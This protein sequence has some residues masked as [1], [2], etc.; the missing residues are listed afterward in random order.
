MNTATTTADDPSTRGAG[1]IRRC[2]L[3]Q[4]FSA[5]EGL[6]WRSRRLDARRLVLG[7]EPG[8]GELVV[9]DGKASRRHCELVHQPESGRYRLR[10]LGSKNG[11][12]LDAVRVESEILLGCAVVRVGGALFVYNEVETPLRFDQLPNE[13]GVSPV[14]AMANRMID[15]AASAELPVL[16]TGPTG[17]GKELLARRLHE[18]SGRRG[19]FVPV[20]CAGFSR[21]LVGSELFGHVK[22]AFSGANSNRA[23]LFAAAAEGTIFLDEIADLPLDQQPALLRALQDRRIRPVGADREQSV[24]A[25]V[26]TATH[27]DLDEMQVR[28][29]FRDD[30]YA[31]IASVHVRLP[32]L[33]ERREELLSL[34]RDAAGYSMPPLQ[35]EAAEALLLH[36]WPYNVREVH[37]AAAAVRL[38]AGGAESLGPDLLPAAI[39]HSRDARLTAPEADTP[40][41]P[42]HLS[43]LMKRHAGN[44]T[45]VGRALGRSRQQIY[46]LLRLY[47]LDLD[48][49]R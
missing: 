46:R 42:T 11:T 30:L 48:D 32:G 40:I 16:I 28:G 3:T 34:F 13:V 24:D 33:T 31:R 27:R 4:V 5:T 6:L 45:D 41:D 36:G 43:R 14:R 17:A 26:V 21:E 47:R 15:L 37:Q 7:R 1:P 38:F 10:D 23:G 35:L 19:P 8:D 18:A 49:F 25:R 9:D 12:F 22:G 29:L 39:R 2:F 44:V 20:N